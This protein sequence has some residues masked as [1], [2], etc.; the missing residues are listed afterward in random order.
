[1]F[2]T[3]RKLDLVTDTITLVINYVKSNGYKLPIESIDKCVNKIVDSLLLFVN[4]EG[5]GGYNNEYLL[6]EVQEIFSK[7]FVESLIDFHQKEGE[8]K[9]MKIIDQNIDY[10]LEISFNLIIKYNGKE[11]LNMR[12]G[13]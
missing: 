7:I 3:E 9:L 5:N 10:S 4:E 6:N 8:I 2:K 11:K 12:G 13:C 1:M